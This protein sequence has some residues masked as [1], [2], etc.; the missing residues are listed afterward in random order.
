VLLLQLLLLTMLSLC[1]STMTRT[2][3]SACPPRR[4]LEAP[5]RAAPTW[6]R[7]ASA[8]SLCQAAQVPA[9]QADEAARSH[10]H[11]NACAMPQF[12]RHMTQQSSRMVP[13]SDCASPVPQASREARVLSS[14]MSIIGRSGPLSHGQVMPV[15]SPFTM[16]VRLFERQSLWHDM[17]ALI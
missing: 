13:M 11:P 10:L 14:R 7:T 5:A 3:A 2:R 16:Y 9:L 17:P 6:T 4:V 12:F 1:C 15:P 8:A